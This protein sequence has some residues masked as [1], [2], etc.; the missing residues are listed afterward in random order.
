MSEVNER[1]HVRLVVVED[2][3][4]IRE[5]L[6]AGL[7]FAGYDVRTVADGGAALDLLAAQDADLVVLDVNLPV[8]DGFEVCRRLRAAGDDVPVIFLTARR[9]TGDLRAG[10]GGGGDDYL[11]K[12]FSLDELTFRIEAVLRRAGARGARGAVASRLVCGRVELD[13]ATHQVWSAGDEVQLT[14]TEFRLLRTL[15]VNVDHVLTRM[16]ILDLVWDYDF[17]GDWQI[18]ETYVSSLRKKIEIGDAARIVHTV[19][20]I[21]YVARRPGLA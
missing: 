15:L 4:S 11:T 5:L 10:F 1:P 20:G 2:D 16:Q 18:I 21:G 7:R 8:I 14:P 3:E 13:E 19:R 12:P 6:A 17:E 9:E